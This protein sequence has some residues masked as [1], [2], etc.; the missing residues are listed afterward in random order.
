MYSDQQGAS[1]MPDA[2]VEQDVQLL[3]HF[4]GMLESHRQRVKELEEQV[5]KL[6]YELDMN[7]NHDMADQGKHVDIAG[8]VTHQYVCSKCG[9]A[10]WR[11][12]EDE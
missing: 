6:R 9:Y 3:K 12:K 1:K 11:F 2:Q 8:I 4:E 5:V 7:C 10:A